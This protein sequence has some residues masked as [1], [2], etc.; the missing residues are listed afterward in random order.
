[1]WH[2]LQSRSSWGWKLHNSIPFTILSSFLLI[3]YS[4]KFFAFQAFFLL[5][6]QRS[7]S[8]VL[9]FNFIKEFFPSTLILTLISGSRRTEWPIMH[10]PALQSDTMESV[11]KFYRNCF[12][13]CC[14][15]VVCLFPVFRNSV[16]KGNIK[17]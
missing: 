3:V 7:L 2:K 6:S 9:Q 12:N 16:Q 4:S 10:T 17:V 8:F 13:C 14:P 15:K 5:R 11:M 1:M